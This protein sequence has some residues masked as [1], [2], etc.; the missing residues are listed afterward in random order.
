MIPS[1]AGFL[2]S[3]FEI[4]EME[5]RTYGMDPDRLNI[6]GFAEGRQALE[7]ALLKALNTERYQYSIYSWNYGVELTD[8]YGEPISY[9]LPEIK[10]RICEALMWDS[11]VSAVDGF[12]FRTE[13]GAV[14]AAFTVHTA[15]G[16]YE[17]RRT[18]EV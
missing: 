12:T 8:L 13:R 5:T 11:R 7:Q 2:A 1:A 9:V 17:M 18:V 4:S 14:Q 15:F 6:K 10:R 3:G 16:E